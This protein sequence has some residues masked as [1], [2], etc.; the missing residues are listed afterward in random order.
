MEKDTELEVSEIEMGTH[1]IT[2]FGSPS[3]NILE[4]GFKMDKFIKKE[5]KEIETFQEDR[6]RHMPGDPNVY[7]PY[8][9]P[10]ILDKK[11]HRH[12]H[13]RL[14]RKPTEADLEKVKLGLRLYI[15]NLSKVKVTYIKQYD[16]DGLGYPPIPKDKE[17]YLEWIDWLRTGEWFNGF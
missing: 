3:M 7:H 9:G 5:W 17:K 16:T 11:H 8:G 15:I 2:V 10:D 13:I 14:G 6:L 4:L 1:F 12:F